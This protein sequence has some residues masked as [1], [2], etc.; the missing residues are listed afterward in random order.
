[1]K[2]RKKKTIIAS[3]SITLAVFSLLLSL[4]PEDCFKC[5]KLLKDYSDWTNIIVNRLILL[6]IVFAGVYFSCLIFFA[7][8]RRVSISE[9]NNVIQIEYGNIMA[10]NKGK[11]II[12][13]D[14]C[15]TTTVGEKPGEI[16]PE[17]LCGQYLKMHPELDIQELIHEAGVEPEDE[18]SLFEGKAR[19]KS[20]TIVPNGNDLLMAFARLDENGRATMTYI[21]YLDCL[22]VL[23]E[24]INIYHGTSDVYV[25]ILGSNITQLDNDLTQQQLLDI[26]I[27]SYRL[28]TKRM[29]RP[30]KLHI[31]CKHREGFSLNEVF[32]IR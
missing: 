19:Y 7:L 18:R 8:R 6:L 1:M 23:W 15:Y 25:P 12:N 31:V 10:I 13:F 22:N 32:G 20:G 30:Y 17:S 9:R 11:R 14:E 5:I 24:Q 29:R 21:Q 28:S 26:M 2:N 4:I 16:K 3:S 27:G